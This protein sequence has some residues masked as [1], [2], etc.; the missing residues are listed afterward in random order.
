MECIEGNPCT[1]AWVGDY[2]NEDG[3]FDGRYTR[4]VYDKV[5]G[6]R[7]L[8]ELPFQKV[9]ETHRDGF[10]VNRT[11]R[12]CIDLAEYAAH[13]S[14]SDGW[15]VHPLPL[16]T[17]I[18]NGRGGGDYWDGHPNSDTVGAWAMDV[19]E[20]THGR[21]SGCQDADYGRYRF[22]EGELDK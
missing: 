15:C 22:M 21:P 16:L 1:V 10:I 6:A 14:T 11:K 5:W 9:P 20:Y 2:A 3:D 8:P 18:G 13:A 7:E 19:I 12:I 4:G 17:A